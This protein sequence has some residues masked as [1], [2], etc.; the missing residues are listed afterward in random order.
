MRIDDERWEAA[1][2]AV[3]RSSV[4]ACQAS[5]PHLCERG[6]RIVFVIPTLAMTGMAG[7]VPYTAAAE[8]QHLLAKSAARQ[9]G[10]EGILVN[11]VA[12]DPILFGI[13]PR[14]GLED[15]DDP[16]GLTE[17]ALRRSGDAEL[18]VGPAVVFL[19]GPSAHF[20]TGNTLVLD[21]GA[22]MVS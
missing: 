15:A 12:P 19:L 14:E 2:E 11:C 22:W 13:P 9:W 20:V 18:D 7:F 6:G 21:G 5:Y 10:P 1:C 17:R 4:F 3:L 16:F 8:G